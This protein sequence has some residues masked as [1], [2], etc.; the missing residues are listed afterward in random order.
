MEYE[1]FEEAKYYKDD[2]K[3]TWADLRPPFATS[4]KQWELPVDEIYE[5]EMVLQHTPRYMTTIQSRAINKAIAIILHLPPPMDIMHPIT[6][7]E[8]F[9]GWKRIVKLRYKKKKKT[10]YSCAI[11]NNAIRKM[12]DFIQHEMFLI[13]STFFYV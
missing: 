7:L 1:I 2:D 8:L 10:L 3:L 13:Y 12:T 5:E 11:C 6:F 4:L 9:S